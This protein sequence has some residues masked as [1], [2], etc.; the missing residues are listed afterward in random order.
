MCLALATCSMLRQ[1]RSHIQ[2]TIQIQF[3]NISIQIHFHYRVYYGSY[4]LI[5]HYIHY[6]T[7]LK[8]QHIK[9]EDFL[10]R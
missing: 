8:I 1:S 6:S 4:T 7:R 9:I 10:G 3:T 5:L 2:Y